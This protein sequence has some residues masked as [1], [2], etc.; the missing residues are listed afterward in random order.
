[1][2]ARPAA[3]IALDQRA[4]FVHCALV[5]ARHKASEH[6]RVEHALLDSHIDDRRGSLKP[7]LQIETAAATAREWSGIAAACTREERRLAKIKH[8][9]QA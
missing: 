9:A 6:R 1:M 4:Y 5:A 3:A 2:S 8:G 7:L